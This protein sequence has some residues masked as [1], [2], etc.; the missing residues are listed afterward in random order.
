MTLSDNVMYLKGVGPKKAELLKKLGIYTVGDLL[1]HLPRNYLDFTHPTTIENA[2]PDEVNIIEGRVVSKMPP[3]RIRKGMTIYRLVFTDG[4]SDMTVVIYNAEYA[5]SSLKI[6][7]DYILCGKVT[8]NFTSKEMSSPIILKSGAKNRILPIYSLTEGITQNYLRSCMEKA[9]T[10][11]DNESLET[12]PEELRNKFSL[13]P[14]DKAIHFIHFPENITDTHIARRRLAFD[15]VLTLRLGML[16]MRQNHLSMVGKKLKPYTIYDYTSSLGFIL[17]NA[18]TRAINECLFDMCR[19]VPMRRLILGDVGSGKTAVAAA[20]CYFTHLNGSQSVLMAPTEILATQHFETLNKFLS[21]LGVKVCLLTGSL[22]AKQK[23]LV[24]DEILSGEAS[25]IVGTHAVL[26]D[27]VEY[28]DLA[29]VITDEQH[30]FGVE[31]RATLEKKGNHP[32]CLVMSATPIPRTL[33]LMIYGELDISVLDELPKGRQKIETF[34]VTGKLRE[35]AYGFVKARLDEGRQAYFVCPAIDENDQSGVKSVKEYGKR[36]RENEFKDYK[37]EILHGDMPA[38]KKDEVMKAFKE[39]KIDILVST[40]VIEVGVDVPNA[41]V[42]LIEN[43]DR[44]G[45]SQLHQLRGRVGRGIHQSYC[46]LITDTNSETGKKRLKVLASESDGF[47]ISEADLELRGPGDFFGSAQH[48]LPKFKIADIA[49]DSEILK[50]AQTA[51][52]FIDENRLLERQDFKRL[53]F[54]VDKLFENNAVN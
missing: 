53:K 42:M 51:A 18:Q 49:L 3:A 19:E 50:S 33:A 16:K 45:L 20:C 26:Q 48:G 54:Q 4:I 44:F 9:V 6:G 37:V 27:S 46:I 15:E 43:A 32:H 23:K 10:A 40:T 29:L 34:A 31:Q 1:Y 30:R 41:V 2:L 47:K 38:Q 14:L 28:K 35:R 11:L 36:L 7:E 21:H 5:F 52:E 8:G 24:K 39:G 12:L 22:T 17:T 13:I 25:V